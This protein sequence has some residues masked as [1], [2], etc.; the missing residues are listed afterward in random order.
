METFTNLP[1]DSQSPL[2]TLKE[3]KGNR[4]SPEGSGAVV[5]RAR[6]TVDEQRAKVSA[7]AARKQSY[8]HGPETAWADF[9][10]VVINKLM[11]YADAYWYAARASQMMS[12]P[13][14]VWT[15]ISSTEEYRLEAK[16]KTLKLANTLA[17]G[18]TED[19]CFF[20][21]WCG[22]RSIVVAEGVNPNV[23]GN[24]AGSRARKRKDGAA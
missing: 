16:T 2:L 4:E 24:H 13:W 23:N 5:P 19:L 6:L 15:R 14:Q 21:P 1:I 11:S 8:F 9:T 7:E 10:N 22:A 17:T 20:F 3:G 12:W 18:R